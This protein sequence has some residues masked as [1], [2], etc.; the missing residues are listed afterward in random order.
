MDMTNDAQER[1]MDITNDAQDIP[2]DTVLYLHLLAK[3]S[4]CP[5]LQAE[6]SVQG[7]R[8]EGQRGA[9]TQPLVWEQPARQGQGTRPALRQ[10]SCFVGP[11]TSSLIVLARHA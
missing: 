3:S 1:P 10:H 4:G 11:H 5:G 9:A 8:H 2:D 6:E 7:Q